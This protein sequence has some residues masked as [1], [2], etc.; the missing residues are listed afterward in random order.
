MKDI[1]FG[2]IRCYA[3]NLEPT[4]ENKKMLLNKQAIMD[5]LSNETKQN[6][7]VVAYEDVDKVDVQDIVDYCNK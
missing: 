4:T 1:T 6:S 7:F 2:D 5:P 3:E